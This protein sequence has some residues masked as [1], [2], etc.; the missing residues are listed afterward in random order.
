MTTQRDNLI[1]RGK[2]AA[3]RSILAAVKTRYF[4]EIWYILESWFLALKAKRVL[5]VGHGFGLVAEALA[6]SGWDVTVVDP[7]LKAL[8]DLK[9][10]FAK[11]GLAAA[12]EQAEPDALPFA[13]GAFTAVASINMLELANNSYKA[14]HEIARVLAP[15]GRAVITTFNKL[16]PWGL[17]AVMRAIRPDDDRR[18]VRYLAKGE[19]KKVLKATQLGVESIKD[20][21]AYLPAFGTGIKLPLAGA[22]V[23]LVVKSEQVSTKGMEQSLRPRSR[24]SMSRKTPKSSK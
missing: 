23:A 17:P 24:P 20:R 3:R 12:F 14:G 7:S 2:D 16:G 15:G 18:A 21:G 9:D 1:A 13:S 10:R 8:T 22:F 4:P 11:V 19:L 6:K 5:V